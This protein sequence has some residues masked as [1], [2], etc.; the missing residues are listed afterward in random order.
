VVSLGGGAILDPETQADLVGLPVA[1]MTVSPEAVS[2][3]IGTGRPL[4]AKG[5]VGAWQRLVSARREIYETLADR[6]WDTSHRPMD[7][8]AREMADWVRSEQTK[9][10]R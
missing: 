10:E 8:I 2:S 1:L 5:G 6:T 3:R 9:A 7:E 4:L